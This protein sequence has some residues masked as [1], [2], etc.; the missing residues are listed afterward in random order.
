MYTQTSENRELNLVVSTRCNL[1]CS[2]C[3]LHKNNSY[4]K[5]DDNIKKALEDGSFFDNIGKSLDKMN[6]LKSSFTAINLWGAETT[7]HLDLL[8]KSLSRIFNEYRNINQFNFST[9]MAYDVNQIIGLF[10]TIEE[11]APRPITVNLQVSIDGPDSVLDKTR[12][13]K[14]EVIRYNVDQIIDYC[15]SHVMRNLAIAIIYKTTIPYDIMAEVC[16]SKSSY[17]DY[18]GFFNDEMCRFESRSINKHLAF[19]TPN[20]ISCAPV[21]PTDF[22]T[23]QGIYAADRARFIDQFDLRQEGLKYF[24]ATNLPLD[25]YNHPY[26]YNEQ[27]TSSAACGQGDNV[28]LFR[29]DGSIV[30]CTSAIMED[31][32][33]YIAEVQGDGQWDKGIDTIL[34]WFIYPNRD[35]ISPSTIKKQLQMK[36]DFWKYHFQYL[37]TVTLAMMYDMAEVKQ[38]SELYRSDGRTL[39]R[40]GLK[41]IS[42]TAC[43]YNNMKAN[44]DPFIPQAGIIRVAC[45]GILEFADVKGC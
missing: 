44:G 41:I 27:Y 7:V 21:A 14:N 28:L 39:M 24:W 29:W 30:P 13:V 33:D 43:Y 12:M 6:Y 19:K 40:H 4:I 23:E 15:N 2:Y 36:K 42:R 31:S 38:I 35:D 10:K 1:H 26:K 8:S 32:P 9:N 45:N 11:V 16:S 20:C 25:L 3:F 17:I 37:K 22:T 18:V 34:P 5:E